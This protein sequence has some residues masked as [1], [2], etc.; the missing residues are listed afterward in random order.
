MFFSRKFACI[1]LDFVNIANIEYH[2]SVK[3]II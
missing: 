2:L 1:L 3:F